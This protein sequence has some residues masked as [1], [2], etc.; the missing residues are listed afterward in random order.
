MP[1]QSRNV[2]YGIA[3]CLIVWLIWLSSMRPEVIDFLHLEC[4]HLFA[5]PGLPQSNT[6]KHHARL[7]L[8]VDAPFPRL[9]LSS[10]LSVLSRAQEVARIRQ[11]DGANQ[12]AIPRGHGT[13][14]PPRYH[15]PSVM[16]PPFTHDPMLTCQAIVCCGSLFFFSC[17]HSLARG[18]E[19]K[20]GA[21]LHGRQPHA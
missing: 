12:P 2:M 5:R 13:P 7:L 6:Q 17:W 4:L 16:R 1:G 9:K 15:Q 3:F 11:W 8:T 10:L 18:G 20:P 19:S 21:Q 14:S